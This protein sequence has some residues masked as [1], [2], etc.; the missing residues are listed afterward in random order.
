MG[1]ECRD[2]LP[3]LLDI[4]GGWNASIEGDFDGRPLTQL[5]RADPSRNWR[6]WIDLEHNIYGFP[7]NHWN[8]LTDGSVKYI[9]NAATTAQ[10]F[11]NLTAD[12]GERI[13]LAKDPRYRD[14][15]NVWRGRLVAQFHAEGRGPIWV[16]KDGQLPARM[17]C[18][19]SPNWDDGSGKKP[20]ACKRA[21]WPQPRDSEAAEIVI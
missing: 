15:V 4:L 12:P 8:A 18:N 21:P 7:T 14:M 2:L 1:T 13:D 5:L 3:T 11:F 17:P 20:K 19:F 10:S 6:Q 9:F 16:T